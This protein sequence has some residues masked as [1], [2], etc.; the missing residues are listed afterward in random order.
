MLDEHYGVVMTF[1][2]LNKELYMLHQGYQE[3]MSE[4]GMWLAWH[5]WIIQTEFLRHIRDEHLERV[6][7]DHSYEGPKE[8]YQEMLAHKTED[9]W[10]ATYAKLLKAVRQIER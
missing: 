10:Y 3:G 4:Y 5:I 7:H 1:D 9:V 8:E 2:V 6:K